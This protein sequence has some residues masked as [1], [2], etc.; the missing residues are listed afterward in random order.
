MLAPVHGRAQPAAPLAADAE[1]PAGYREAIDAA[2]AEFADGHH[3]EARA[4]FR[5]AHELLPNART[6]RGIGM[7]AFELRDYAEAV[8]MLGAAL[9]DPRRP[10]TDEQRAQVGAALARAEAFVGRYEVSLP[11][12]AALHVDASATPAVLEA[13]GTLLL[14]LG[15]H[16]VTTRRD[17]LPL[18]EVRVEVRGGERGRLELAPL[19]VVPEPPTSQ[20][21]RAPP[22][23]APASP[24]TASGSDPAPAVALLTSGGVAVV[25]GAVLLRLGVADA[26]SVTDAPAGT[27]WSSLSDAYDRAP[28]L[29]GVGGVL[30]GAGAAAAVVG[31]VWL[32][33]SETATGDARAMRLELGPGSITW[34]GKF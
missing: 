34:R 20:A 3:A 9:D 11:A 10:L 19:D 2:V 33:L 28:V 1:P 12:G 13:D 16:T 4:L 6:L 7:C 29:Q 25:A 5:R 14:S 32:G 15:V 30:L 26:A 21:D 23:P 27:P 18:G 8:R 17:G 24:P 22:L 31:G